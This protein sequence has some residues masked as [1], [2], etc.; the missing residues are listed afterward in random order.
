MD[1][2]R[3]INEKRATPSIDTAPDPDPE[4]AKSPAAETRNEDEKTAHHASAFKNMGFIDRFLA[5][6]IFLAMAVGIILGNFVPNTTE[7]L[8]KG[9]F[10][11]VSVPIGERDTPCS[12]QYALLVD[13]ADKFTL[14][15]KR[16]VCSS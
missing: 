9:K 5:V 2:S 12:F 7:A 14:V 13:I 8:Q 11:G 3:K 15:L 6:W 16:L 1:S 4:S 10:V